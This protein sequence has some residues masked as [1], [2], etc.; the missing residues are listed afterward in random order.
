MIDGHGDDA[1]RYGGRV[2]V[3]FSTNIHQRV[4]HSGLLAHLAA[5]GDIFS[6][7]PEPEPRSLEHFLAGEAGVGDDCVMAT[8]GAT[9]MIYLLA[10]SRSGGHSAVVAP[11]FREYQDACGIFRHEVTFLSSIRDIPRDADM[12]WLCN[13]NNPTG[14]V[15]GRT[16]LLEAVDSRPGTLFVIDQAYADYSVREV[17]SPRDVVSRDNIV[18]LHSL[19]K[20]FAIPGLRVG[21]AMGR[22]SALDRV[23]R[24]RMPWSVNS[25]AS[26]ASRYLLAHCCDY[27][28]DH[29][30][31]NAESVRIAESLNGMGISSEP[32]DCNFFLAE[33]PTGKASSLKEWLVEHHGILIR[34]ASNFEGLGDRHFRI[35]AQG[36]R[37]ND[38][39]I[40]A[41]RE[42]ISL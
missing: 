30:G 26:E 35:A 37:E 32:T 14:R 5:V 31:L 1:F 36:R 3:N 4:D 27:A 33:L 23:R 22:A 25:V 39:L 18:S 24:L 40:N 16:E 34:D 42:W 12:L 2:R 11:T 8:N 20:R 19:T 6:S 13:P 10:Q 17:L 28:I 41:I 38:E 15:T 29:A 7:Y 21:Y 9:E